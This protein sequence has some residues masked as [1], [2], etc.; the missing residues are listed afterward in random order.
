MLV[1]TPR[2]LML[3][4][5]GHAANNDKSREDRAKDSHYSTYNCKLTPEGRRQAAILGKWLASKEGYYFDRYFSSPYVR[6]LE[7]F[8]IAFPGIKPTIDARLMELRR[9]MEDIL[10]DKQ[11]RNRLHL[12]EWKR[13]EAEGPYHFKPLNGE[14]WDDVEIRLRSF[15]Q[16]LQLECHDKDVVV[17]G[18]GKTTAIWE[19]P[20]F[21]NLSP[22][23]TIEK[24]KTDPPKNASVTIYECKNGILVPTLVNFAPWE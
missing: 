24:Y 12:K 11:M 17:T 1:P 21:G 18:H 4:R 13:R 23:E 19:G 3:I 9:G 20:I 5:H 8:E 16:T 2:S 7:T 6:P 15:Y 10:T 22:E 14:S